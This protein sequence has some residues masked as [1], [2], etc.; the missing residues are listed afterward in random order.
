[1]SAQE[2]P[3]GQMVAALQAMTEQLEPVFEAAQGARAKMEALGFSPTAS[4]AVAVQMLQS[5]LARMLGG[6]S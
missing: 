2:N 1:M 3:A 6:A 4:E 5:L